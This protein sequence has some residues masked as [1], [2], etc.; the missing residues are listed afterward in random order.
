MTLAAL[1]A[2]K[3]EALFAAGQAAVYAGLLH[4]ATG[5]VKR[6]GT[7]YNARGWARYRFLDI[8]GTEPSAEHCALDPAPLPDCCLIQEWLQAQPKTKPPRSVIRAVKPAPLLAPLEKPG[9]KVDPATGFVV[10]TLMRPTADDYWFEW[11]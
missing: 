4:Y 11:K 3:L 2:G 6:D 1:R 10:G 8:F 9:P 5:R 7:P